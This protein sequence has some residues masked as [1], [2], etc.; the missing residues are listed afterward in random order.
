M[1]IQ[2][3]LQCRIKR[4][5]AQN[6]AVIKL[7]F[8]MKFVI[9]QCVVNSEMQLWSPWQYSKV[10]HERRL[11]PHDDYPLSSFITNLVCILFAPPSL[12]TNLL[13]IYILYSPENKPLPL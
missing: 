3:I 6:L 9:I 12:L 5:R 4:A 10:T 8:Y 13:Q 11:A 7:I 2:Y 1:I